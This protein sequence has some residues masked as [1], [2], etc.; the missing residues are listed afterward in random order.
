MSI[1]A[2]KADAAAGG[3]FAQAR[4]RMVEEI[5]AMASRTAAL[6][7]R[8]AFSPAVMAAMGKVP[9]HLFV[10]PEDIGSAYRNHPL[11][12]GSGQTISQPYIVALSTELVQPREHHRV[13]EIGTGSGYQAAVLA[14]LVREVYSVEIVESLALQAGERLQRLGY[15]NVRVRRS[16]GHVGW[17]EASPFDAIVVTAAAVRVPAALVD[18]L[19]PGG[20]MVIPVGEQGR[21]QELTLV[22]KAGDGRI[23]QRVI[24][25]VMFV[26]M[27]GG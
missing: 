4:A 12:I 14:E 20:R 10:P 27:T 25:S 21:S 22:E 1:F 6:T 2:S 8:Q 17:P 16:D 15:R 3:D 19:R 24:L 9:R 13:L 18:Q 7:G 11:P 5:A 23:S 26:P